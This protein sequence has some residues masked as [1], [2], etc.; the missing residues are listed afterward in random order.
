MEQA[1]DLK[2]W[3]EVLVYLPTH[4][5]GGSILELTV[6]IALTPYSGPSVYLAEG[7][8]FVSEVLAAKSLMQQDVRTPLTNGQWIFAPSFS[9]DIRTFLSLHFDITYTSPET[10]L[11]LSTN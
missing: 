7:A 1:L 6:I 2:Y 8:F 5:R 9:L 10:F 11:C 3:M 4:L